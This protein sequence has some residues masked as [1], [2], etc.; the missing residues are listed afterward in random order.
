MVNVRLAEKEDF[1]FF[2]KLKCEESNSYW[3]G[4]G[5][6]PLRENIYKF[7]ESCIE[8]QEAFD[9]RKILIVC[10]G[11]LKVGHLYIIPDGKN[12][13]LPVAISEDYQ[14]KGYSKQAILRGLEY[15]KGLGFSRMVGHIR[16]D[17]M[18]S[19]NAYK[20]CGMYLTGECIYKDVSA[21]ENDK[22]IVKSV[23][24]NEVAIDL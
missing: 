2:Y 4:N 8:K 6:T 9:Q 15:A 21:M 14:G 13:D 10:D 5:E 7:F 17:N 12:F 1:E 22:V 11:N 18:A 3:T 16:E 23:K 24:M 19:Y 20:K